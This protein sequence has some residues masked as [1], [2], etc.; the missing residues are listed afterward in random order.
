MPVGLRLDLVSSIILLPS[1]LSS[2]LGYTDVIFVLEDVDAVSN[3][4]KRRDGKKT[5][6]IMHVEN[7]DLPLGKSIWRML[8][9]S[10]DE[11]CQAL[12][13]TLL[14]K[15]ERLK[16]EATKPENLK[17]LI[18]GIADLPGLSLVGSSDEALRKV[19]DRVIEAIGRAMN[20]KD[21]VNQFLYTHVKPLM[22]LI[23][24][25]AEID[26]A[27]VDVLLSPIELTESPGLV[28][29]S[30]QHDD[31]NKAVPDVFLNDDANDVA[32]KSSNGPYPG[33]AK[34][35][36]IEKDCLNLSGLLNV[37]DGVVET[38]GRMLIMT[39]NHPEMLDP[40]LIRPGRID[41]KFFLGFMAALDIILLLE[42]YF[43]V[44]ATTNQRIRV[45]EAIHGNPSAN[46]PAL[47]STPAQVEQLA[48]EH[49][50]ME[51]MI[52]AL[53]EKGRPRVLHTM[54]NLEKPSPACR[55]SSVSTITFGV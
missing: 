24:N 44:K 50:D 27:L 10:G 37:L 22:V 23:E 17:S 51:D 47:N 3:V 25:G 11:N 30:Y 5:A 34:K 46:R 35:S 21:A 48:A 7:V 2:Q 54:E 45:E 49:D 36:F 12:V 13:T 4:V 33:K 31:F 16:S 42:H 14:E 55:A 18:S 29:V 19:G 39:T 15:S 20:G 28:D 1:N 41:K 52:C 6:D 38:P 32:F 43:Q 9:E 8:L 26:D 40:A 53:E